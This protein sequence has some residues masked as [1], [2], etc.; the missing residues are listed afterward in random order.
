MKTKKLIRNIVIAAV[1]VVLIVAAI[2]L[3]LAFR[4]D[5]H[6]LNWF[7]RGRKAASAD[8]VSVS[9]IEY[10]LTLD[11]TLNNYSYY[12]IDFSTYSDEQI[13][14]L[15]ENAAKQALLLPSPHR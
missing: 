7:E 5:G 2:L 10:A 14:N 1:V 13:K 9:M 11:T 4:K 8:G 3:T 15:Q 6:G 12:G